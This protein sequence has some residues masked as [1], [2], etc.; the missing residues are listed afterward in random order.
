MVNLAGQADCDKYI[1]GELRRSRIEIIEGEPL[2]GEV[3]ATLTGKLGPF[4]FRRAW[5]YWVVKGPMPLDAARTLYDDPAGREGVRVHGHCGCPPPDEWVTW[6]TPDGREIIGASNRDELRR[7]IKDDPKYAAEVAL[8]AFD[9]EPDLERVGFI[10]TYHVDSEIGL[11]LLAD[12]IRANF[13][14]EPPAPAPR[15]ATENEP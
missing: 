12:T 2:P 1:R 3:P 9:D 13:D 14:V 8:L 7:L 15:G 5:Y 10:E 11:R 4:T 6:R